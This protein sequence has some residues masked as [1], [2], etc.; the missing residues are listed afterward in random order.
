MNRLLL[1]LILTLAI[2]VPLLVNV[3][4]WNIYAYL[5]FGEKDLIFASACGV[6]HNAW[7]E[8]IE[9]E[10]VGGYDLPNGFITTILDVGFLNL[11]LERRG[12][13]LTPFSFRLIRPDEFLDYRGFVFPWLLLLIIP[14]AITLVSKLTEN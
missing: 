7:A 12:E 9:E 8:H 3:I 13:P 6:S 5:D 10:L 4:G 1:P 2:F 14:L 11:F